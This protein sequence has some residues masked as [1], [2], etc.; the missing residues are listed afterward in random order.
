[1]K[2][3]YPEN[4]DLI[5]DLIEA[6]LGFSFSCGD[7]VLKN[8]TYELVIK[9]RGFQVQPYEVKGVFSDSFDC[10]PYF[11]VPIWMGIF[12]SILFIVIT[13]IGVY[14]LF[15][16]RTMDRFDDPKGKTIAVGTTA[17]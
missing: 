4:I 7:L 11:T 16:V 2:K 12:V 17:D 3:K 10:V 1:M 14:A 8:N 5:G 15:A 6:P 13:N 9:I